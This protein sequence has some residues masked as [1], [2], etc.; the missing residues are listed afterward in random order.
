VETT[1]AHGP[2]S[3]ADER[4]SSVIHMKMQLLSC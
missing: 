4:P 3:K 1:V 2:R